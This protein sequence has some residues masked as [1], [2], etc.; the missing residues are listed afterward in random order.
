MDLNGDVDSTD[1]GLLVNNFGSTTELDWIDGNVAHNA[2]VGFG[3]DVINS[4]DLGL[5]LNN[6]GFNS[7]AAASAVPEPS[8]FVLLLTVLSV[9]YTH[10][11]L[12]TI[13]SV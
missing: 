2:I 4:S 9:S 10:L 5:L 11:T 13:Y 3:E 7:A 6:F 8:S 12:P 1:L